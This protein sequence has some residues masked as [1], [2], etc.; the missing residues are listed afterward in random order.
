MPRLTTHLMLTAAAVM[1]LSWTASSRAQ[2]RPESS[3]KRAAALVEAVRSGDRSAVR[4]L[5]QSGVSV[6]ARDARGSTALHY[7]VSKVSARPGTTGA[8]GLTVEL[9]KYGADPSLRDARGMTALARAIPMG[10]EALFEKL[11]E[12]GG[13]PNEMLPIGMSLLAMAE[14]VGNEG[15]AEAI[16]DAGGVHGS[17]LEQAISD[18][19]PRIGE[20]MQAARRYF[21]LTNR[22]GVQQSAQEEEETLVSLAKRFLPDFFASHPDAEARLRESFRDGSEVRTCAGCDKQ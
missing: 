20:F 4:G 19:L 12:A 9:L 1:V 14:L 11:L 7:A 6:N 13:D 10:S 21:A 22:A 18:D 16:R 5:L 17:P 8:Y 2:E 15:A 3:D